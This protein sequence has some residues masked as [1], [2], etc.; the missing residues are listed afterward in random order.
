M[1]VVSTYVGVS[2]QAGWEYVMEC[3]LVCIWEHAQEYASVHLENIHES[4]QLSRLG[5]CHRVKLGAT[6]RVCIGVFLRIY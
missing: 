2:S 4:V 1:S 6:M 3:N 5:V